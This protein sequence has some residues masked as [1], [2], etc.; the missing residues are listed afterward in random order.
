MSLKS[1]TAGTLKW[2]VVDRVSTQV[3]YAV[4]G[5][6]LARVLS[7]E[8]FGL[9]GAILVIQAFASLLVDSGFSYAL[10]QRKQPSRLDYSTVLWFNMAVSIAIYMILWMA[11]PLIAQWFHAP[12]LVAMSRVM[13]V[14]F[15]L[16]ASVIVQTNILMKRMDV[17]MVAVS[18]SAGLIAG[19]IVGIVLALKGYGAW[20]MV[21]QAITVGAVKAALLW[22]TGRWWP[23]MRFSWAALRSYFGIGSRM[24]ATS[25]LNTVFQNIYSFFIGNRTGM[26]AL[27]YYTQAD[28]WSKM[29]ISSL[30]QVLTSSFLPALSAVQ[31][32]KPRFDNITRRLNRFTS[33]LTFPALIG[34]VVCA[35]SIFHVLFGSKWDAAILLF[36]LLMVRGIFT[37][38]TGLWNNYILALGYARHIMWLEVM[39]DSVA[40]AALLLSLPYITLSSEGN[41][42]E[43]IAIVLWGQIA[44]SAA[45][46]VATLIVT[47]RLTGQSV[48]SYVRDMLPY[49]ALSLVIGSAMWGVGHL[50]SNASLRLATEMAI[51]ITAYLVANRLLG[52]KIQAEAIDYLLKRKRD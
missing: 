22:A 24:M 52:S 29:G 25:F 18:N 44:A 26:V 43:G 2:N 23:M 20:A 7:Q 9:V 38:L 51:G 27:G 1:R 28:K 17:R 40:L 10:I 34:L 41:P 16:N 30:S 50:I 45:T 47:V 21:W 8:A 37:V 33:Y 11:A 14:S 19:G 4:T 12:A 13:F 3:L 35:T 15:I 5:I 48:M 6:V 32:D 46:W 31:D 36:Q 42:V 49:L 39:R